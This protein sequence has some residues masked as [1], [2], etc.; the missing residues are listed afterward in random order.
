MEDAGGSGPSELRGDGDGGPAE[1]A[2][3]PGLGRRSERNSKSEIR[4]RTRIPESS[5]SAQRLGWGL[6]EVVRDLAAVAAETPP[7]SELGSWNLPEGRGDPGGSP[8][9]PSELPNAEGWSAS[10]KLPKDLK[11]PILIPCDLKTHRMPGEE[12]DK[13]VQI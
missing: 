9:A 6:G 8:A 2:A 3:A 1:F 13:K 10:E 11:I 4:C 5:S 7:A 12:P